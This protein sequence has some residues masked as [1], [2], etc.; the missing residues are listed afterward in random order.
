MHLNF[1]CIVLNHKMRKKSA[2]VIGAGFSGLSAASHL[3]KEGYAVRVLE[4]N[5]I[6]GGRARKL[7]EQGFTFDMG[8]SWYWMPDVF[9]RFFESFGKKTADFYQLE[10]LDPSYRI[11]WGKNDHTDLPADFNSFLEMFESFELGS[12]AKLEAFLKEAEFKYRVGINKL[13]YKKSASPLEFIDPE[14]MTGVFKLHVFKSFHDYVRKYFKNPK[15]IQML[16]FPVLFLGGTPKTTPALY[17][18]MNYGDIKLGTWY[19]QGGMYKVVEGMVDLAKSLGVEFEYGNPVHKL[20][21]QNREIKQVLLN[22]HGYTADV[23]VASADYHH[24][25]QSL[26]PDGYRQYTD[27][28]WENRVMSPSSLIFYLGIN[29]PVGKLK[30]HTLFFDEDFSKHA[31]EIYNDPKWPERPSIYLSNTSKT[32][33]SVAPEGMENIM[34][35]IP[36]APDLNDSEEVR[37][38]Y[39][40]Y[41]IEKLE[42]YTGESIRDNIVYKRSYAH[43]DFANDYNAFK[44]NAY[45]LANTLMQ[46][47]F[48]KPKLQSKKVKNLFYAGQLTVPG[49]G[50]PPTIISGEVAAREIVKQFKN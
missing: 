3:A 50:V 42:N 23:V 15:L 8:P 24:V 34:V 45:G 49:P 5:D 1:V 29:K 21:I 14:L 16:E 39:F 44:G 37:E 25:E 28:Y 18:L 27:N 38:K 48:L 30:H 22:S 47:A 33:D 32:D 9:D 7:E 10:R 4:K 35:L 36:V 46:T 13:V 12:A 6:P 43:R 20:D 26:L 19:P 40:D 2:I 17:S 11:V 31:D 41:V